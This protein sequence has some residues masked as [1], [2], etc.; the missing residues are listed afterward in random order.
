MTRRVFLAAFLPGKETLNHVIDALGGSNF[1]NMQNRVETGRAVTVYRNQLTGLSQTKTYTEFV[2]GGVRE[3]QYFGKNSDAGVLF[4]DGK[5]WDITLKGARP[6]D[7]ET[8]ERYHLS[9]QHNVFYILRQRL[10]EMTVELSGH[11]V[12]ENQSTGI[13]DFYD[14]NNQNVRVWV[15]A[16]TYLPVRQRWYRR[17]NGTGYRYE[18]VTHFTKYREQNGIFWPYDLERERDGD[19]TAEIYNDNVKFNQPV[20]ESIFNLPPGIK[21]L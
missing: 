7:A 10:K 21:L 11:E 1:L 16:Y 20:S 13:L 19:R 12:V 8:M 6:M 9:L 2:P 3:R 14:Q 18:E 15:N 17:E 5:G 4:M